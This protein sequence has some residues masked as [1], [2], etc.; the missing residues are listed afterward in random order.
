MSG[1]RPEISNFQQG[2]RTQLERGKLDNEL[3]FALIELL[4]NYKEILD[5]TQEETAT[6]AQISTIL[7]QAVNDIWQSNAKQSKAT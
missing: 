6:L 7:Q 4:A 1:V 2:V 3:L 5:L